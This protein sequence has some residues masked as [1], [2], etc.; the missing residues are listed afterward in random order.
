MEKGILFPKAKK[1]V[2]ESKKTFCFA[3]VH[4]SALWDR[5]KESK[6]YRK[7]RMVSHKQANRFDAII[8]NVILKYF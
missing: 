8:Q 4:E 7:P 6:L 3:D 5:N 2:R 1:T